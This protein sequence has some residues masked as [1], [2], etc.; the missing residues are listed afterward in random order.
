M[1]SIEELLSQVSGKSYDHE[2]RAIY[3]VKTRKFHM[4]FSFDGTHSDIQVDTNSGDDSVAFI[5]NTKRRDVEIRDDEGFLTDISFKKKQE[6]WKKDIKKYF[7]GFKIIGGFLRY[8][9][10]G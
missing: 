7:R 6:M 8:T 2:Y 9:H 3:N 5:V 10:L 1:K 4:I